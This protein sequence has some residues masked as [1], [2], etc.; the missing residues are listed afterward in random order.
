MTLGS[1]ADA[2]VRLIVWCHSAAIKSRTG[3]ALRAGI[4][5]PEWRERLVCSKCAAARMTWCDGSR[6]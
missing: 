6:R 1:A 2:C 5:V 3:R 4:A